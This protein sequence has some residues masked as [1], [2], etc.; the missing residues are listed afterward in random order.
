MELISAR[1]HGVV[2]VPTAGLP[3]LRRKVADLDSYFLN[4]VQS[5]L[6]HLAELP[7]KAVGG[8]LALNANGLSI[9]RH[10]VYAERIVAL[11]CR[12]RHQ[13]N[14]LQWVANVAKAGSWAQRDGG[15][16]VQPLRAD[17]MAQLAAF[18]LQQRCGVGDGDGLG[19]G[20]DLEWHIDSKRVGYLYRN[21]LAD[22]SLESRNCDR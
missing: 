3:V 4:R 2:E 8:V 17:V 16:I 18:G 1:L 6:V 20:P 10:P 22:E 7:V 19:C 11:K 15:E 21:V 14:H 13:G 5:R 12:T 9:G